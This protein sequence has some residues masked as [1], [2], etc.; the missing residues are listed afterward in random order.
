MRV[1]F[2]PPRPELRPYIESFW[3]FESPVGMPPT[4]RSMAAPNRCPKLIVPYENSL[5]S[6]AAAKAK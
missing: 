6:V 3:V 4:D 2:V 5:V 1:S